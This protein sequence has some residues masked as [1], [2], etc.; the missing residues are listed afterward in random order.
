MKQLPDLILEFTESRSAH[1]RAERTVEWYAQQLGTYAAYVASSGVARNSAYEPETIE[2]FM[3][4]ERKRGVSDSTIQARFR[5]LRAFFKWQTR[6]TKRGGESFDNPL[7]YIDLPSVAK[8]KPKVASVV[9]LKRL[10]ASIAS[11][12]FR[13]IRDKFT[14]RLLWSTGV[15]VGEACKLELCDIDMANG[16]LMVRDG[17]GGKDRICPFDESFKTA[18][19]EYLLNRPSTECARLL[20]TCGGKTKDFSAGLLPNGVRQMLRR[21]C[22]DAG[23]PLINPHSIRHL[24][25]I[26][27][28]N[29]G[30]QLSA[31]SA[32][33]GHSSVSFT[34]SHYARWMSSGLRREYD[35]A[36]RNLST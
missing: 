22:D 19:L 11:E 4:H 34:A 1:G 32:A 30:M 21:R 29:N 31:V 15:R 13:D 12:D 8:K 33:M 6:R 14:V 35:N 20:L 2:A 26:E 16:F 3:I 9:N 28:L 27:R 36:T 17:K 23:I 18:Y 5:A 7:D 10:I 25:A 24:Y